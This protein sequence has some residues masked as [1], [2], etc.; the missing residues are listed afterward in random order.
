M[1]NT[2]SPATGKRYPFLMV[3]RAFGLARSSAYAMSSSPEGEAAGRRGPKT[4]ISDERLLG[5]IRHILADSRFV[6][7][8]HRKVHAR[9]R[10]KRGIRVG[11]AR[12][13]RLMRQ[14]GLLAPSRPRHVHGDPAHSGT[15]VTDRPNQMWGTDGTRFYTRKEGW[16]WFFHA[17]DHA[18]DYVVGH[19]VAKVGDRFAALEPIHQGI[20]KGF[21]RY[22]QDVALGL[23]FRMDWATQYTSDTFGSEIRFLG[24]KISHAFVGEP[25]CNGVAERFIRTLKEECL[26]LHD[27]EDLD[28]ARGV[29]ADFVDTYNH[30]WLIE[31]L[32]YRTPAEARADLLKEA[33]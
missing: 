28:Q 23:R 7:E 26:W 16:C 22:G 17:I 31:R 20:R 25:Q 12:V 29:I 27:F 13:L 9:L 24:G 11:R 14:Q 3:C 8:G 30:E 5:A 19:H 10:K 2:V 4:S 15:I 6:T 21:G 18:D 33:A 1:K 32:G